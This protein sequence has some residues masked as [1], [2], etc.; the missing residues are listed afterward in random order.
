MYNLVIENDDYFS[1]LGGLRRGKTEMR[2]KIDELTKECEE[3]F[4]KLEHYEG[5]KEKQI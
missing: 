3:V 4:C 1:E 5:I 2:E